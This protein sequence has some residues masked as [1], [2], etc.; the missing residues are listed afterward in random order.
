MSHHAAESRRK[1][2]RHAVVLLYQHDVTGLP[3]QELIAASERD[4]GG[5]IDEFTQALVD[6]VSVDLDHLDRLITDAADRW[7]TER[8]APLERNIMRVAVHEILDIPEIPT[9]VSINEA[10]A[11]AKTFCAAETPAF[12]NG[13]LG[14]V[15]REAGQ[16][17]ASDG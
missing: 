4:R 2:R 6:G 15:A 9:A 14:R 3:M 16:E 13:I 17:E 8:I 7:T 12:V 1:A 5:D 10:V 11:Q